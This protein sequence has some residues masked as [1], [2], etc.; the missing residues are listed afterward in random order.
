MYQPG[1]SYKRA[2]VL[3]MLASICLTTLVREVGGHPLGNFTIN[4]YSRL[5]LSS[6]LVRVRYVLDMAEVPTLQELMT[7]TGQA[8]SRPSPSQLDDYAARAANG[9]VKLLNLVIDGASEPLSVVDSKV[10]LIDA[11]SGQTMRIE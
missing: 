11:T 8:D 1:H 5:E 4:H 10:N 2:V 9:Y 6:A 3:A 7:I